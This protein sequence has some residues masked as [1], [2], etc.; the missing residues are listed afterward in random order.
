M[1][2]LRVNKKARRNSISGN[3]SFGK[4]IE[5]VKLT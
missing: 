5:E 3:Y 4:T 1:T 2:R